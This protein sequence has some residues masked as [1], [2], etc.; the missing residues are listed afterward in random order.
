MRRVMID[1]ETMG[2]GP[3]G[4]IIQIGLVDFDQ[5]GA[6]G[7]TAT[8]INVSLESSM[9]AGLSVDARTVMWWLAQSD[10]ARAGLRKDR[11]PLVVAMRKA[12]A[13]LEGADEVWSHATFDFVIF[14]NALRALGMTEVSY[15]VSRD[16][17]T[18]FALKKPAPIKRQ[19]THHNALDD[20]IFQADLV[21]CL[22]DSDGNFVLK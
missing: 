15:R 1:L 9:R 8:L 16:L 6:F 18:L 17:R 20:A 11:Q 10:E 21:A 4:A 2:T 3:T 12:R 13:F 22:L 5:L 14:Q 19:G 7:S